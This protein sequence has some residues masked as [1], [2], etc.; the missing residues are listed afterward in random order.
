MPDD[1]DREMNT[2]AGRIRATV[3]ENLVEKFRAASGLS[4]ADFRSCTPTQCGEICAID[5]SDVVLL[6][7][8][9]MALVLFR[10]AQS[11]FRNLERGR[12]SLSPLKCAIIG[13]GVENQ[14]FPVLYRECFGQA[15]GT[16]LGN[17]DRSKAAGILRDTL[18]YWVA[19]QMAGSLE[20]GAILLRDGPLRVS[21]ASHDTILTR[22]EQA[23]R[24]RAIDLAGVSKRTQA[25]WGGGHPLLPSLNGLAAFFG[26]EAPWW[27][28]I[29]PAILDHAQFPQWQHGRMY[30]A[31]L[32]PRAKSPLKIELQKDLPESQAPGI[33]NRL[34]ACSGDGRIP[35]YPYPLFDAHRTVVL[36]EEIVEQVRSDLLR[37]I[38][39]TGM[40]RQTFDIMFGDYHDEFA[41]Y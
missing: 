30:V 16:P 26:I 1:Y 29:D 9:S 32:H 38:A 14:D 22:I 10:A 17:E 25:T 20:P 31:C 41:R 13:L 34:A 23:C 36:N 24:S 19:E 12:R 37:R 39:G 2:A 6:E 11:T 5:G 3:P 21:H 33:M 15:P 4:R 7:S 40:G 8:G 28:Q 27:I 35:G 18:E